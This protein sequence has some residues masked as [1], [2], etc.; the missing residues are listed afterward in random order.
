MTPQKAFE[1][2]TISRFDLKT[3]ATAKG[4]CVSIFLPLPDPQEVPARLK[5]AIRA[6][7]RSLTDKSG[8]LVQPICALA[9]N[10]EAEGKWGAGLVVFRSPDL[11]EHFWAWKLSKELVTVGRRFQIRP[12]LSSLRTDQ[13]FYILALSQ[14]EI[15]LLHCTDGQSK[16]V[17]LPASVP[18]S[19]H[20]AM[21]SSQPD[22]VL[23]GRSSG[24][25][26]MGS[27]KG[28]LFG[29]NSDRDAK[30]EYMLHFFH[31]ID[32]G[33]QSVLRNETAPL[34]LAGVDSEVA[35]YRRVNNYPRLLEKALPGAPAGF[36]PSELQQ[37]A[38]EIVAERLRER[39]EKAL[40]QFEKHRN[41]ESVTFNAHYI[42]KR[43]GE[44]RVAQLFLREDAELKGADGEDLLN[45]AALETLLHGGQVFVL[46]PGKAPEKA[47]TAAVLRF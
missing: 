7:E 23:D 12:F 8:A 43:A 32:K 35:L 42:V 14:K 10:I 36:K 11:F 13:R 28:V 22:H 37:R 15:H 41:T 34:V 6:V 3:L 27:M 30:G 39:F 24:G 16:E 31:S 29:T 40:A 45:Q 25:P 46:E 26:G 5:N 44:G 38:Q 1:A 33:L 20:E 47:M 2:N 18:R 4:P 9:D 21:Q 19:L 17:R